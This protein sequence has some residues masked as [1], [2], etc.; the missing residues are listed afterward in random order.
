MT[1]SCCMACCSTGR[2]SLKETVIWIKTGPYAFTSP[3]RKRKRSCAEAAKWRR[4]HFKSWSHHH[5]GLLC[6]CGQN[7]RSVPNWARGPRPSRTGVTC[8]T[9]VPPTYFLLSYDPT[10]NVTGL[11]FMK[12]CKIIDKTYELVNIYNKIM[13]KFYR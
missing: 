12:N 8:A 9:P 11:F 13:C 5:R 7:P 6:L 1:Q 10:P 3:W 4:E 2:T